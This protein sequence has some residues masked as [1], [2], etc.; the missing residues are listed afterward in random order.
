MP[1]TTNYGWTTPADTDLVKDG[2]SAIRTLG[3]AIDTTVFNNASA[4]ISKTI[5][6]AKG[7]LIAAT[8]ADT[9]ARL[10]VGTD[11][12]ILSADSTAS[13]GLKWISAGAG[14]T[15]LSTTTLSGNTNITSISQSYNDLLIVVENW[16]LDVD[17]QIQ[18]RLNNQTGSVYF[19]RFDQLKYDNTTATESSAPATKFFLNYNSYAD[20][21]AGNYFTTIYI[22]QYTNTNIYKI[23]ET[24]SYFEDS[25]AT[26]Y[27]LERGSCAMK[28]TSAINEINFIQVAGTINGGS[29]KI[30]GVK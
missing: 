22:P 15:L 13:T 6:D 11:G 4:A 27:T 5:V 14:Q 9:I 26:G 19:N 28:Y 17:G 18:F 29:V 2:A 25:T 24:M 12:Q 21:G 30:Y 20:G 16:R 10:A 8:A 3:S 23:V 1:T 7:D